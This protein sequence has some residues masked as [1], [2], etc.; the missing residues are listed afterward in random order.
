MESKKHIVG[1]IPAR[2]TSTRYPGKPLASILGMPMIGHV[3]KRAK[4]SASLDEVYIV[5]PDEVIADY[6]KSI[7]AK[8]VMGR[9]DHPG[10]VDITAEALSKIEAETGKTADIIA[11]LQ[12]DEPMIVPDMIDLAIRPFL[13]DSKVQVVNLMAPI[14]SEEEHNDPNYPK[15]VVDLENNALY[16]SREPIPSKKKWDGK[17]ERR[18]Y[19]QVCIIPF[20]RDALIQFGLWGPTPLERIESIDMNRFLEHGHKVRMVY[21]EYETYSVDTPQDLSKVEKHMLQDPLVK[22]YA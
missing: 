14:R 1:I 17:R 15:V 3:Y 20:N 5:T 21:E 7:G 10:C 19:K 6:A 9:N 4:M 12:G 22:Q 11:M 13:E 2:M 8:V 18:L 16:F